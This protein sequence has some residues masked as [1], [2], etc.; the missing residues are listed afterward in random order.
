MR[1]FYDSSGNAVYP[2]RRAYSLLL[3]PALFTGFFT[4]VGIV[5]Y[6]YT[7]EYQALFMPLFAFVLFAVVALTTAA[8]GVSYRLGDRDL[9]VKNSFKSAAIPV[10][11]IAR[12]YLLDQERA[13]RFLTAL[14]QPYVDATRAYDFSAWKSS[15]KRNSELIRYMSVP[16][17]TSSRSAGRPNNIVEFKALSRGSYVLVETRDG[18]RLMLTPVDAEG[19]YDELR[20]RGVAAG[21]PEA[22]VAN[23]TNRAER[24]EDD[25]RDRFP[26]KFVRIYR[27]VS[28][29]IAAVFV[30]VVL[31]GLIFNPGGKK[32]SAPRTEPVAVAPAAP[33]PETASYPA[34][35][36][37]AGW[38]DGNT[39]RVRVDSMYW[40]PEDQPRETR[41]SLMRE[42]GK[43]GAASAFAYFV[44]NEYAEKNGIEPKD[45]RWDKGVQALKDWAH[46]IPKKLIHED[47]GDRL[48]FGKF[49]YEYSKP[50]LRDEAVRIFGSFR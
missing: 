40:P 12:A 9:M 15:L 17:V 11:D 43:A 6:V 18:R 30:A 50:G 47:L 37:E 39:L 49:V 4:V 3:V 46:D 42:F 36:P 33:L 34:E 28:F 19:F 21:D 29:G 25:R 23:E 38:V 22:A 2:P 45:M 5:V 8:K 31:I 48:R 14:E 26:K 35:R 20:S 7:R 13:G 41:I 24:V 44:A 16:L 27:I 32:E 10:R 1:S